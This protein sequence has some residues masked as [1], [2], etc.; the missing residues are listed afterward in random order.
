MAKVCV[1]SIIVVRVEFLEC[2]FVFVRV[3]L[4]I[5]YQKFRKILCFLYKFLVCTIVFQQKVVIKV[6]MCCPEKSRVK[7]M[8]IAATSDG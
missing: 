8:K 3:Y 4:C 7:A 5:S 2:V 6:T 1:K